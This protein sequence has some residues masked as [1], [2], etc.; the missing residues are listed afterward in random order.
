MQIYSLELEETLLQQAKNHRVEKVVVGGAVLSKDLSSVLLLKRHPSDF[1]PYIE[2]LPSGGVETG[3]TLRDA[4]VREIKEETGLTAQGVAYYINSF[5]YHSRS[6]KLS[7]QFNF[8]VTT[9]CLEPIILSPEEHS[10]YSWSPLDFKE[11]S[12]SQKMQEVFTII[13]KAKNSFILV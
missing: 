6:G 2:E 5:D 4:L 3:E 11:N 13:L 12:I 10:S 9:V 7:R 1:M 8:V